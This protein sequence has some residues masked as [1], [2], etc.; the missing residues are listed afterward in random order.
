MTYLMWIVAI[1]SLVGTVMNARRQRWC[2]ILWG[3]TNLCWTAYDVS[4]HAWP[5][6]ALMAV[7][8]ALSIYGWVQWVR[9]DTGEPEEAFEKQ[10]SIEK[11]GG[12]D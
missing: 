7:Y 1:V 2:F 11:N 12:L 10:S 9:I 4:L 3:A 5:Q 8:F 6:A